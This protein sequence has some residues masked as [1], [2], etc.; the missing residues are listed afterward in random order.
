MDGRLLFRI[1][2]MGRSMHV[3]VVIICCF[4]LLQCQMLVAC[5]YNYLDFLSVFDILPQFAM[6]YWM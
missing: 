6:L 2:Q 3:S 4:M 1:L 5:L